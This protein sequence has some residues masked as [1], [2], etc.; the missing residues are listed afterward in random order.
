MKAL[1]ILAILFLLVSASCEK[2][3]GDFAWYKYA[4]TGCAD[5]WEAGSNST[6]QELT[7]A[8][9]NYLKGQ[10]ISI[11]RIQIGYDAALHETC[12]AC[13]CRTGKYIQV[14]VSADSEAKL[15]TLGFF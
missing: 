2:E 6:D 4:Q 14:Y 10:S 5:K 15:Q 9:T 12:K 8:V 13:F 11:K 1:R 7:D 3:T